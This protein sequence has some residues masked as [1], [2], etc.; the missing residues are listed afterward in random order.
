VKTHLLSIFLVMGGLVAG[1][2]NSPRQ[3]NAQTAA[4]DAASGQ[5]VSLPAQGFQ[6]AWRAKVDSD[7]LQRLYLTEDFV[8]A[9]DSANYVHVLQRGSGRLVF[10]QQIAKAGTQL[11]GPVQ[12]KE[13]IF[14][15]ATSTLEV[16]DRKGKLERSMPTNTI[17]SAAVVDKDRGM[18]YL[19]SGVRIEA[20]EAKPEPYRVVP[21]WSKMAFTSG[22]FTAAPAVHQGVVF[23]GCRDG[24]VYAM[25]GDDGLAIWPLQRDSGFGFRTFGSIL[26]DVKADGSGVY[27]ASTDSKLYCLDLNTGMVRWSYYAQEKLDENNAPVLGNDLVYLYHRGA[28]VVAIEKSSTEAPVRSAKWA[29]KNAIQFLAQ[30]DKTAYLLG[31]DR[32]IMAVDK[33]NG[34]VKLTSQRNDFAAF[35]ANPKDATI[36]AATAGGD[37]YAIKP[38]VRAGAMGELV[39]E[40]E[41]KPLELA[42]RQ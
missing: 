19:G 12:Y 11:F 14:F 17:A 37:V 36:Y 23:A 35:A 38:V 41:A 31:A 9:Y 27:A 13:W 8:F 28:G 7:S 2:Q 26:A 21:K 39:L 15:P 4:D 5:I 34:A 10:G 32:R 22:Q 33:Q 30:D 18:I 1:C 24:G 20:I 40:T 25:K 3:R 29:V 16:Y 6:A 42:A